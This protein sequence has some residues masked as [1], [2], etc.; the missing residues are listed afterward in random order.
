MNDCPK[1]ISDIEFSEEKDNVIIF[2]SSELNRYVKLRCR[3]RKSV[4]QLMELF[5]GEHSLVQIE[6]YC[7]QN[8]ISINMPMFIN[9]LSKNGFFV[10]DETKKQM[11][12]ELDMLSIKLFEKKFGNYKVSDRCV[13]IAKCIITLCNFCILSIFLYSIF[14]FEAVMKIFNLKMFTY[15]SSYLSAF[16]ITFVLSTVSLFLHELGHVLF[17]I[18]KGLGIEKIGIYLY[19]GF[20]PKWLIKFRSLQIAPKK[21]KLI[22]LF[23]GMYCNLVITFISIF[24]YTLHPSNEICKC[25]IVSNISIIFNCMSP[26]K[27]T[28]GYFIFSIWLGINNW[29]LTMLKN[30]KNFG[31]LEWNRRSVVRNIYMC[32]NVVFYIVKIFLLYY[33]I[34]K[35]L[36]E[37]TSFTYGFV[38]IMGVIHIFVIGYNIRKSFI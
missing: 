9:E 25:L 2:G 35:S 18:Y 33:W 26:F 13:K 8:N 14:H 1:L 24:L 38:V 36:L 15:K 4:E 27:L 11:N 10:N 31:K 19:L 3:S 12:N 23:G 6:N 17:G 5:D 30:I 21:D 34:T 16:L 37:V 20:M 22:V 28:D 29:R 32:I 7:K